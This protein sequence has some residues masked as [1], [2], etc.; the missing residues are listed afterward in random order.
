MYNFYLGTDNVLIGTE[1]VLSAFLGKE[2]T[3]E[4]NREHPFGEVIFRL[5]AEPRWPFKSF[6]SRR[7]H[8]IKGGPLHLTVHRGTALTTWVLDRLPLEY[9]TPSVVDLH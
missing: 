3:G 8:R 4:Y 2:I 1:R 7:R 6:S 5:P 9:T